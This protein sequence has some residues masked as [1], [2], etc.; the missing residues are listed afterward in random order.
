MGCAGFDT[1][2]RCARPTYFGRH[3]TDVLLLL[4][5][6]IVCPWSLSQFGC[7]P[8]VVFGFTY[9]SIGFTY[10]SKKSLCP[11]S[12][13]QFQRHSSMNT[14]V[15]LL[16]WQLVLLLPLYSS[17]P[18]DKPRHSKTFLPMRAVKHGKKPEMSS[19]ITHHANCVDSGSKKTKNNVTIAD[20]P[21]YTSKY[22]YM[23]AL[24]IYLVYNKDTEALSLSL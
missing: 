18:P 22:I 9:T 3:S 12:L 15:W 8:S 1:V 19:R 4:K 21:A 13:Y 7:H 14:V 24:Y 11:W 2:D 20:V 5:N 16:S 17:T 23:I 6:L 10:T